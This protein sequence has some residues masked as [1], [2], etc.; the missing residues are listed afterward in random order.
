[1]EEMNMS[2]WRVRRTQE[3]RVCASLHKFHKYS[4]PLLLMSSGYA[5]LDIGSLLLPWEITISPASSAIG[6]EAYKKRESSTIWGYCS[7]CLCRH[8]HK[9]SETHT[10]THSSSIYICIYKVYTWRTGE[11]GCQLLFRPFTQPFLLRFF[12][13]FVFF[14]FLLLFYYL[15]LPSTHTVEVMVIFSFQSFT[16]PL[17]W[18]CSV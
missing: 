15:C 14:V 3:D 16:N 1:M 12:G 4:A 11:T 10:H 9:Q 7:P 2:Y 8:Q 13:F 18:S 6:I 17:K 5:P